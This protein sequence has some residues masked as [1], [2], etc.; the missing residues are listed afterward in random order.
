MLTTKIALEESGDSNLSKGAGTSFTGR[1]LYKLLP[2][3]A[4]NYDLRSTITSKTLPREKSCSS[5]H[6]C[7]GNADTGIQTSMSLEE[8]IGVGGGAIVEL[9]AGFAARKLSLP[10]S[11]SNIFAHLLQHGMLTVSILPTIFS[12]LSLD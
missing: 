4:S 8:S 12:M 7:S 5:F 9:P 2:R 11:F 6:S 3:T 10:K 1:F